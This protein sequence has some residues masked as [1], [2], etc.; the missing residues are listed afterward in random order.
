MNV[1]KLII[2]LADY[3]ETKRKEA[4]EGFFTFEGSS[5]Y[6]MFMEHNDTVDK[7]VPNE[8]FLRNGSLAGHRK[9]GQLQL[10]SD[11]VSG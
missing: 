3:Q 8:N 4:E 7:E 5:S 10:N 1:V 9:R 2:L 11:G 6:E